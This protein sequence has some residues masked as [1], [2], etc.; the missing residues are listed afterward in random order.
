M[1]WISIIT[2]LLTAVNLIVCLLLILLVLLQR[3]KNEGLGAAFGGETASNLF[4]AQTTNV[5]ANLTRWMGGL[6]LAIC[7]AIAIL[8]T[9][10]KDRQ[11][12]IG[13][14][15]KRVEAEKSERD[16]QKASEEA[17]KAAAE[18]AEAA[19]RP[20]IPTSTTTDPVAVPPVKSPDAKPDMPAAPPA[21]K[22]ESPKPADSKPPEPTPKESKPADAKPAV[23]KSADEKPPAPVV[24]PAPS[25]TQGN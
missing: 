19:T 4:G 3:P 9:F 24:P 10:D 20:P 21:A 6:F 8:G 23:E 5:L 14:Y 15:I 18:K 11:G 2:N 1:N 7:L 25:G 13:V 17:A 22:P 12:K 16:K